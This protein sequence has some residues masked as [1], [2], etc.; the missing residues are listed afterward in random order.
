MDIPATPMVLKAVP[1][2]F[3]QVR[4]LL[5]SENL[6]VEDISPDL[7]NFFVIRDNQTVVGVIALEVYGRDG[8]LRSMAVH[9]QHRSKSLG[10]ALLKSLIDHA[11]EVVTTLYLITTTAEKYF[12]KRGF[13]SVPRENI[14]SLIQSSKEFTTLCPT[15]A[16]VMKKDLQEQPAK[17]RILFVCVENSN[18]SQV[19]EAF[20]R[21]HGANLV[22]AYSAGSKPS[23]IVNPK[24]I[25]AMKEVGYDLSTHQSKSLQE[26][27]QF[28]PFDAVVTMG[29]GDACPW[30]PAKEF[31]DW[32][33]PDPKNLPPGDFNKVRDYIEEKV[34]ELLKTI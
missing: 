18:R 16:T 28:A 24:A 34:K 6:P 30:M 13:E 7:P 11:R 4:Q 27:Q 23:G 15:T 22:E 29:C 20:A 19:S 3:D 17:K 8:L 10:D 25:A 5:H 14:S 31:I 1:A 9:P 33:I 2:D 26:V 21:K 32:Q 12:L